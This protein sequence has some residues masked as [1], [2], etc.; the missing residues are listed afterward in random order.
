MSTL[1]LLG[2]GASYGSDNA[3]TPPLGADL[4]QALCA[5]NPQGWGALP[6]SLLSVFYTDFEEGMVLANQTHSHSLP[7]L[8]RAMAAYFFNFLPR[9]S[10]LY[11]HLAERIK[12]ARWDGA[13]CTLNYE[14]YMELC[15]SHVGLQPVV[16][17][18]SSVGRTVELCYPH[19][20]CHFF[21]ESVRGSSQ[22]ISFSGMNIRTSG[23]I[24]VIS[25]PNEFQ[26]R[27][28][29]DAFPP[30][31]SYFEPQKI[32]T[33]GANFVEGQR[34]RFDELVQDADTIV[35]I[36]LRVRT[37][38]EHIWS[39]LR[40]APARIVYCSGNAA[41]EEFRDWSKAQRSESDDLVLSGYFADEFESLLEELGI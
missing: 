22:G 26:D 18:A 3:G 17:Q 29:N 4:A 35:V 14:R 37:H 36:G 15:L 12:T 19:G 33:S 2:A 9:T 32:T 25:D 21:C 28:N 38:D 16:G 34:Q 6:E 13:I 41:G 27:I 10:N 5:F 7:V 20:C 1:L 24:K 31:M 40:N 30:V 39:P 23:P 11:V 8:Q